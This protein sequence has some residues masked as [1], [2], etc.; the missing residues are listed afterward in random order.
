MKSAGHLQRLIISGMVGLALMA[1]AAAAL[2]GPGAGLKL[3]APLSDAD[4][5][6]LGLEKQ[7]EFALK[8]LPAPYL[9]IEV[10]RTGCGHCLAT[11]GPM[12]RLFHL[13]QGSDLKDRVKVIGV[14]EGDSPQALGRYR[15]KCQVA[16]PLIPDP[17]WEVLERYRL[18]GTPALLLLDRAGT[19]KYRHS[20]AFD[21]AEQVL[22]ELRRAMKD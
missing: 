19:V 8:D 16:F 6:Y 12:N 5:H 11:V 1:A 18:S 7:G 21:H 14:G 4:R 15:T 2:A 3:A 10:M 20:G 22:K 13:V 17:D 9:L